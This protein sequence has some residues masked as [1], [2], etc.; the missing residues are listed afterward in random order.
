MNYSSL[1]CD[2]LVRA[3]AESDD[4]EIWQEFVC[5][6][7]PLIS[8]TVSR[9]TYRY[10]LRDPEL[11]KDL[12]QDTFVKI[13]ANNRRLLRDFKPQ[14]PNAF[15]GMVKVTANHV[16]HDHI[17]KFGVPK[18]GPGIVDVEL[19]EAEEFAQGLLADSE[20][21]MENLLRL[22]EV[23]ECLRDKFDARDQ[24][25]FWLYFRYELTAREISAI[26][27][28]KLSEKGVES[29]IQRVK[30]HVRENLGEPQ[31]DEKKG[32]P[33]NP[34]GKTKP[35]DAANGKANSGDAG[36]E[37]AKAAS[38]SDGKTES[39]DEGNPDDPPLSKGEGQS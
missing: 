5:R 16:A 26:P 4:P 10:G 9:V 14:F 17:R 18:P 29:V 32:K 27:S 20:T 12:V 2:E 23:E 19:D 11:V 24:E 34:G 28:Y 36:D 22:Q 37:K 3:C 38:A 33:K 30:H 7:T 31:P 39:W 21:N 6:F 8:I 35:G 15:F 13:C 1:S 25:I